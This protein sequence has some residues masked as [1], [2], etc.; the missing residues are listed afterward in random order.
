[1][2]LVPREGSFNMHEP[3]EKL[4]LHV[5][6]ILILLLIQYNHEEQPPPPTFAISAVP[7]PPS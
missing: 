1:M 3:T 2:K 6:Y 5:Q 4:L 7:N